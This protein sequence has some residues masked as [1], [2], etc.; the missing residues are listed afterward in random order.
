MDNTCRIQ[1]VTKQQN[2]NYYNLINKFYEKTQVP[3]LLNTSFN[4]AGAPIVETFEQAMLV[5]QVSEFKYL[6]VPK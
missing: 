6:Y 4:L 3:I 2:L 1:T 5:C